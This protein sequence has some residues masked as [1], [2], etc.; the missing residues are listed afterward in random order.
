M[1]A[2]QEEMDS[3]RTNHVWDLLDLPPSRKTVGNK[4]V[5]KIKRMVDSVIE[6][7]KARLVAK[8]YKQQQGIDDENTFTPVVRFS[9]ITLTL[10][11]VASMNFE[12]HRIDV[13]IAFLNGELG[14][15]IYMEQPFGFF[16]NLQELK[17]CKLK[18]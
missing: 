7:Y 5:L 17:V 14:E 6:R 16:Q 12:L 10:A 15:E 3:M 13:E 4:W 18:K 2:I 1:E 8:V 11:I 9:S